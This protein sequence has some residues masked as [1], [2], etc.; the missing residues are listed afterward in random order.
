M[1]EGRLISLRMKVAMLFAVLPVA[2]AVPA[3][4]AS[5]LSPKVGVYDCMALNYWSGYLDYK[6]SLKLIAGGRYQHAFGRKGRRLTKPKG[7]SYTVK[8]STI[9]WKGGPMSFKG[10]TAK[11]VKRTGAPLIALY[12][13]GQ[14]SGIS[15]YWIKSLS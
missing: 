3:S 11:V 6:H 2:V 15:C 8:G 9:R 4:P 12:L 10:S 7:G 14:S 1:L 5:A 13:N